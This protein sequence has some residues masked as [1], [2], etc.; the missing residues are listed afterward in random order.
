VGRV[1]AE[2]V[3]VQ[4]LVATAEA[5]TTFLQAYLSAGNYD[6][7]VGLLMD[8]VVVRVEGVVLAKVRAR[9]VS[10]SL[11]LSPS[12]SLCLCHSPSVTHSLC[13]SLSLSH[14]LSHSLSLTPSLS[15]SSPPPALQPARRAAVRA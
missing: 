14:S 7:W 3:W 13:L 2:D 4:A 8:H 15:L 6:A 10:L 12:H 5:A 1:Q 11:S 9:A